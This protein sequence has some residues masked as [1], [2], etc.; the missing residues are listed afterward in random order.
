[1]YNF[2]VMALSRSSY[3]FSCPNYLLAILP[4]F[5]RLSDRDLALLTSTD[6]S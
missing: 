2:A 3:A 4:N 5:E 6:L 1:M